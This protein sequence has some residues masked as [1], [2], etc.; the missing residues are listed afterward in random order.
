MAP[1]RFLGEMNRPNY[2]RRNHRIAC[3]AAAGPLDNA[4]QPNRNNPKHHLKSM[5][6][7]VMTSIAG[8]GINSRTDPAFQLPIKLFSAW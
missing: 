2:S 4:D 6:S 1:G 8:G 7:P 5:K 3:P